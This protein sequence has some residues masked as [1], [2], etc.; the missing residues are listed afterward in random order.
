MQPKGSKEKVAELLGR[1]DTVKSEIAAVQ[2]EVEKF[3]S[4]NMAVAAREAKADLGRLQARQ[5]QIEVDL[6]QLKRYW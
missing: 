6:N 2:R 5:R 3:S 1:L 4:Q